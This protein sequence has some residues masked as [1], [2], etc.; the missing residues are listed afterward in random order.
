MQYRKAGMFPVSQYPNGL[1]IYFDELRVG[2]SRSSVE[3]TSSL[4]AS[5]P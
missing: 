3:L 5:V 2:S 1:T 4:L